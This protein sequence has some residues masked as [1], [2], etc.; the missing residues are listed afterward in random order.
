MNSKTPT[1]F[2]GIAV[3]VAAALGGGAL[4]GTLGLLLPGTGVLR[5]IIAGIG[6]AYLLYLLGRSPARVGRVTSLA[7]WTLAAAGLWLFHPPLGL[8]IVAHVGLTWLIRS[9]HFH[10]GPVAGLMDLA[11]SAL[12]L[13]AAVWA[14]VQ[15][16]SLALSLW[17]FFLVQALFVAIPRRHG[18]ET[19][20][21]ID[22]PPEDPFER[23]HRTAEAAVRK[24]SSLT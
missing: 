21:P 8:Y 18:A 19:R 20:S 6:L 16:G 4:Y 11:L 1:F 2:E 13:A 5:L 12:A 7:G 3:A 23:A 22:V 17:S 15:S 24:L 9:L 10:K 14:A